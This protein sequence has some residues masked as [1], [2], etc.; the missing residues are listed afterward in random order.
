MI[1]PRYKIDKGND[2]SD[3]KTTTKQCHSD[4]I[5]KDDDDSD[6]CNNEDK[7]KDKI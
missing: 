4:K 1:E 5:T 2:E 3:S 7:E 6:N